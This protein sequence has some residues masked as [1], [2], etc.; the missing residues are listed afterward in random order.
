MNGIGIAVDVYD[1]AG[2]IYFRGADLHPGKTMADTGRER[3]ATRTK[4]LDGG[5]SVYDTGYAPGDRTLGVYL[6][7]PTLAIISALSYLVERYSLV[8]VSTKD[9]VYRAIPQRAY[10]DS[11]GMASMILLVT[12]KL[13]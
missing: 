9:G 1:L 10:I 6:P 5:V 11:D 3:R 12:E 13:S 2:S 7:K 8:I 4:T